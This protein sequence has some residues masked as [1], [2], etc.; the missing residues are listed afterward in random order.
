MYILILVFQNH[1]LPNLFY[2]TDL[3]I[4]FFLRL[5]RGKVSVLLPAFNALFVT[6]FVGEEHLITAHLH[7]QMSEDVEN[8]V[9]G[10]RAAV[11]AH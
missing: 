4:A 9:L 7:I 8:N 5:A 2:T 1:D 6:K 3:S 10:R 11:T